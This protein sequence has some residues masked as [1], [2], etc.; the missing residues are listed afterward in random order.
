MNNER[1]V[2]AI[3]FDGKNITGKLEKVVGFGDVAI[4][5]VNED[6]LGLRY[7]FIENV[8]EVEE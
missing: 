2:N 1:L 3:D 6:R 7:A 4:I 8:K 5:R